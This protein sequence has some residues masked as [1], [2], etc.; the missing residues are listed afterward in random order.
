MTRKRRVLLV[1]GGLA[2]A[3][4]LYE[5]AGRVIAYTDDAYVRSDLVA[6]ASQVTGRIIQVDVVDNQAVA[7]GDRLASIDPEPIVQ[8]QKMIAPCLE[9]CSGVRPEADPE[10][11]HRLPQRCPALFTFAPAPEQGD[12]L[13]TQ[14][15]PRSGERQHGEYGP[16]LA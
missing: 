4:I 1:L 5:L 7:K 6:V 12:E 14:Y 2:A 16:G 8:E 9:Q 11:M 10:L 13:C 15:L 3:F